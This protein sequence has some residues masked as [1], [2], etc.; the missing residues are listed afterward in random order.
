M[1]GRWGSGGG[2]EGAHVNM[3]FWFFPFHKTRKERTQSTRSN[4]CEMHLTLASLSRLHGEG[5]FITVILETVTQ[6]ASPT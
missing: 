4:D 3:V 5:E 6:G 1:G 2:G